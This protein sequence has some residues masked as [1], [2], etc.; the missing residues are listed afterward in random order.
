MARPLT[1]TNLTKL[2]LWR[3]ARAFQNFQEFLAPI[4]LQ[5]FLQFLR[6]GASSH[7]S[8]TYQTMV[9]AR[10][11][12]PSEILGIPGTNRAQEIL[13]I[14]AVL[15]LSFYRT[16]LK[17][18]QDPWRLARNVVPCYSSY[19][20]NEIR[21]TDESYWHDSYSF[22]NRQN[23]CHIPD[24]QKSNYPSVWPVEAEREANGRMAKLMGNSNLRGC[25]NDFAD[26]KNPSC[27]ANRMHLWADLLLQK[28]SS[29]MA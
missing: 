12:G 20:L 7:T 29:N 4:G 11:Q 17:P 5:E 22:S 3:S 13:Q 28:S 15:G 10:R 16:Y 2:W 1:P 6:G 9:V 24:P 26:S 27:R 18:S 23:R 14:C 25:G 8:E 19:L 21:P